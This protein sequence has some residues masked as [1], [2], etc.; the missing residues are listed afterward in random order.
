MS[1]L[2]KNIERNYALGIRLINKNSSIWSSFISIASTNDIIS[3]SQSLIS[4]ELKYLKENKH[5][6][7]ALST[8][9]LYETLQF[10]C[11]GLDKAIKKRQINE[12][13]GYELFNNSEW[14]ESVSKFIES[15]ISCRRIISLFPTLVP[16]GQCKKARTKHPVDYQNVK[17]LDSTFKTAVN[18]F[19]ITYLN[20][21]QNKIKLINDNNDNKEDDYCL[22]LS[23][24]DPPEEYDI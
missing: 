15:G 1:K 16:A 5:F 2:N 20:N 22:I 12:F 23:Q 19:L 14:I 18:E 9:D 13:F 7:E 3:L 8:I 10:D 21:I 24:F 6:R 11:E 17:K 4:D